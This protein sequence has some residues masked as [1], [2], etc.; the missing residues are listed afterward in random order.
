MLCKRAQ[1]ELVLK[2]PSAAKYYANIVNSIE[3]R[4]RF[5]LKFLSWMIF[6]LFGY[7]IKAKQCTFRSQKT[8]A[9][10]CLRFIDLNYICIVESS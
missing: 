1:R 10:L 2:L 9:C 3:Q 7:W 5:R 6:L 4:E 8:Q